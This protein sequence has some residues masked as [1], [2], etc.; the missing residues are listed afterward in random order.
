MINI[1]HYIITA[2]ITRL[3]DRK[4]TTDVTIWI[5]AALLACWAFFPGNLAAE[6][7]SYVDKDGVLHFSN[8]P[9][10]RQYRYIGPES[11]SG[12]FYIPFSSAGSGQYDHIIS[13]ASQLYNIRSELIKAVIQVESNFNPRAISP[14]GACGLMQLMPDNWEKFNVND[15]FDPH[16]NV[17]AGTCFLRQLLDRYDSDLTLTLA[18]YN[19]GPGAVDQYKSIPP[20]PETKNYVNNVLKYYK[21]Y[22]TY[23]P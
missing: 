11:S 5:V 14:A 6:I 19:A 18:A 1:I 2:M 15:P 4:L 16:E 23:T 10:S 22:R 12:N 8:V 13:K 17:M 20:Y 21:K 9:T 3:Y 7:Y